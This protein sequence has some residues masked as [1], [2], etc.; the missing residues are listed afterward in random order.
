MAEEIDV[1]I[2]GGGSAG[3]C[4][5]M[6]LAR[7][8]I[9]F[10][11]LERR[12]GALTTGQA[13]G[14][15]CRTVEV[16]ESFG[17]GELLLR[18]ACHVLEL[19]FWEAGTPPMDPDGQDGDAGIRRSHSAADTEPG[20]SHLPHV[21]LAQARVNGLM[22]EEICRAGGSDPIRYGYEVTRVEVDAAAAEDPKAYC[23]VVTAQKDGVE[24]EFRA[25]YVLVRWQVPG[26]EPILAVNP[27][28]NFVGRVAMVR[29]R[30]FGDLWASR[31][32]ATAVM[33]SGASWTCI[34]A[35]IFPTSA[36]RLS[37]RVFPLQVCV[38]CGQ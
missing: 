15:Q 26:R 29:I 17:L 1:L 25:K 35:Q 13:D 38:G 33:S 5:G 18:E 27:W 10:A 19:S 28:L 22:T 30:R 37:V 11:V 3:L 4:T 12:Q 7:C 36:R 9:P 6:W 34:P 21:T 14:V 23:C 24:H 8:G 31:W 2:C 16:F 20:I 32:S